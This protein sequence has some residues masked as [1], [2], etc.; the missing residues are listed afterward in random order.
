VRTEPPVVPPVQSESKRPRRDLLS[1]GNSFMGAKLF[2]WLGG[3]ALFLGVALFVKYSF[4]HDLI[5]P[6]VRVALGFILGAGLVV[7]GLKVSLEK[8]RITAQTLVASGIVSLYAVTF[9][10]DAVYHFAFFGAVPTFLLMTL[11]TAA[12]FILA[13]RLDAQVVAILGILGG[14]LTPVLISTGHDNPLGLFGYLAILVVGLVAV[15]LHRGWFYLVPLG[16]AGT[17]LMLIAWADKF[18]APAR[19]GLRW[20]VWSRILRAVLRRCG[21]GPPLGQG[22]AT[23]GR[24]AIRPACGRLLLRLVFSRLSSCRC[25]N[26]PVLR[27]RSSDEPLCFRPG[28]EGEPGMAGRG[29]R[30]NL[31]GYHGS[32]G[33]RHVSSRNRRRSLSPSASSSARSTSLFILPRAAWNG[34]TPPVLWAAVGMPVVSLVFAFVLA[35][36]PSVGVRPGSCSRSSS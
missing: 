31:R 25:A 21:G 3:F 4:E 8:Y 7:G 35:E 6:Q 19:L 23:P 15:A 17:V 5:P 9:A 30:G 34:Q 26:G 33:D 16:A 10:C 20:W 13:V 28:M 14:F 12:A 11:I 27:V 29:R 32:L 1:T 22:L 24:T 36:E 18:Y 2:A